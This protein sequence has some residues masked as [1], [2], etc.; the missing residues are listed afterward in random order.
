MYKS[1]QTIKERCYNPNNISYKNYGARGIAMSNEWR[2]DFGA[3]FNDMGPKP[4]PE[5]TLERRDNNGNYEKSNCY[6]ATRKVQARNRRD[7]NFLTYD[8]KT[9]CMTDWANDLGISVTAIK[10]RLKKGWS[11]EKAL[12]TP[13]DINF[14]RNSRSPTA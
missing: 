14:I 10:Y 8:G 4:G 1:W 3:F 12:T 5:Y 7:N 13:P 9:Q 11:V 2:H 6:W